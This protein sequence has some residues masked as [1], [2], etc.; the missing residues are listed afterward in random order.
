MRGRN[1]IVFVVL[2][3]LAVAVF[4]ASLCVGRYP[5]SLAEIFSGNQQQLSILT[6]IRLP[7]VVAAACIGASLS[8]AGCVFQT[9]FQNPMA[10]PDLLGA[11]AGACF[12]A[13]LGILLSL[14]GVLVELCAFVFG[15]AAVALTYATAL[16]IRS[17]AHDVLVLILCGMVVGNVFQALTS[18]VKFLADPNSKLPE[19]TFWLMGGLA[20][21]TPA[22]AAV[23]VVTTA[24]GLAAMLCVRWRANAMVLGDFE[25]TTVGVDAKR[26]RAVLVAAATLVTAASVSVAGM[27]GWVGLLVPHLARML[28]G[29]DLRRLLPASLLA[30]ATFL[31]VVDTVC[32]SVY[33]TEI[34]LSILTALIGAPLFLYLIMRQRRAA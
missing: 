16:R 9:I 1:P 5:L 18:A 14:G 31:M 13:A 25:A 22:D 3:I 32:R 33:T 27:V 12:G 8:A 7:R 23:L 6:T 17:A 30:G 34:P 26:L 29:S 21:V 19:I 20:D 10:S 28:V 11:S 15:V 4:V 24:V 2:S